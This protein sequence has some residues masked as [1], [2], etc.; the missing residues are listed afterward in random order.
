MRRLIKIILTDNHEDFRNR[1][2]EWWRE[3]QRDF[4]WR[5][6]RNIYQILIAEILLHRTRAEQVV[7]VY[8][9][10]LDRFPS[11]EN[12]AEASQS[13]IEEILH[14]LGLHW[15]A[16]LLHRMARTICEKNGC[17]IPSNKERL[18]SLPGISHYIASAI[19][20]FALGCPEIM[21]DTNTVRIAGRFFGVEVTDSSRRSKKFRKFLES[22]LDKEH[23]Q[24]FNF[25]MIDLGALVCR[26]SDPHC[27]RCPVKDMCEY[28]T[29]KGGNTGA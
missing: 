16:R 8:N 29:K 24:E 25:A 1:L 6:T 27:G 18:K 10:F 21:L 17:K 7:P 19:R 22:L 15:R 12:I 13:E 28:A 11:I 2:L 9:R 26:S 3:N 4:P 20:C 23:P 5:N 14:P